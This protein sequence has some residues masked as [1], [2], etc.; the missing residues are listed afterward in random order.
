MSVRNEGNILKCTGGE[1]LWGDAETVETGELC[2][3]HRL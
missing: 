2:L 1:K 3:R